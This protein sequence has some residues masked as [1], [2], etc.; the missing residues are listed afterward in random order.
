MQFVYCVQGL[1]QCDDTTVSGLTFE[2]MMLE[3]SCNIA[4]CTYSRR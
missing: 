2:T 4:A 1:P 3:C